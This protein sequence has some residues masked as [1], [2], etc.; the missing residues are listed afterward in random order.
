MIF[1]FE[2][3][4]TG[5]LQQECKRF[6]RGSLGADP[7]LIG[8][9]V[10]SPSEGKKMMVW[11]SSRYSSQGGFALDAELGLVHSVGPGSSIQIPLFSSSPL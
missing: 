3:T 8:G 1:V 7:R 5:G 10:S 4:Q 2:S 9:V 11:R 6:G